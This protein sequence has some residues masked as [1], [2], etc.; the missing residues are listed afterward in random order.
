VP[1]SNHRVWQPLAESNKTIH[2][3]PSLWTPSSSRFADS[4]KFH[5]NLR[6]VAPSS[7]S[8]EARPAGEG[9]Q[10][11]REFRLCQ[12]HEEHR[13]HS[14]QYKPLLYHSNPVVLDTR[15]WPYLFMSKLRFPR[16]VF[17]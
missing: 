15:Q 10:V 12:G 13:I 8:I 14:P 11:R 1:R 9:A 6:V 16:N 3:R 4:R 5:L 2:I 17:A 7:A